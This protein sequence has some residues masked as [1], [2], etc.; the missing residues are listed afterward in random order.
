MTSLEIT[1]RYTRSLS[2][3]GLRPTDAPPWIDEIDNPYLHGFFAPIQ[4]EH[5]LEEVEVVEGEIPEDLYGGYYRNSPNQIYAPKNRYHWFDGDGMINGIWFRDGKASYRNRWIRTK[6]YEMEKEKGTSIW[7][8]VLGPFDF[9]L[10]IAPIK[11]SANT[12]LVYYNHN[13]IA[14][15]YESGE[16][17][18]LDPLT[19]ESKG[20]ETLNGQLTVSISAHA[21]MDLRTG[22]FLYFSY[23]DDAP[24]MHYGVV[25]PNGE[26]HQIP[27]ELP[28]ARRPH[29][30]GMTEH[31]SILHDFPLFH[32]NEMFK[33]TGRRVPVFHQDIPTRFGVIPR[34]G[35][36]DEIRWFECEPCYMLHTINCWEERDWIVMVG[37]R[38]ADP[39]IHPDPQD[40]KLAGLLSYLKLRANLYQWKFNLKTGEVQEGDLDDYNAEFPM[41]HEGYRGR[42][43]RYAYLQ[44]I[45]YEIP[46]LFQG[47]LKYDITTGTILDQYN[48]GEGI[49]GSEAPFAPRVGS[50]SEDDGY[51]VTF[52]TDTED[53]S[54]YCLI[55]HAQHIGEGPI[56]RLKMP[57]R[58]PSGFHTRWVSGESLFENRQ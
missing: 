16:P 2:S 1:N 50:Q 19:L 32:D 43:S 5:T 57:H 15:W 33:K 22:D 12:D 55:F 56:A 3:K 31:Y 26:V 24:Y 39:T 54:S 53:W 40:G 42:P 44:D 47:L 28:G 14:L 38:T 52:T 10:P 11:D 45:P 23:G 7:P 27:I 36:A 25:K 21:H 35:Q 8:G 29:D 51:L 49:Y 34:F 48:Y 46:A 17:Y 13:L 58:L 41:I 9:N 18:I 20:V 4:T 37:C 6:A 30:L